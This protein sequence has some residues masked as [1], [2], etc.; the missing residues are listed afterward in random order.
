MSRMWSYYSASSSGMT[1]APD[2][3]G[4][5]AIGPHGTS[6]PHTDAAGM[7]IIL[8]LSDINITKPGVRPA[9]LVP[10]AQSHG[11][12]RQPT[13]LA[14]T[15]WSFPKERVEIIGARGGAANIRQDFAIIV[16]FLVARN[17]GHA[18]TRMVELHYGLAEGC[19]ADATNSRMAL[20]PYLV[21]SWSVGL[22]GTLRGN[23]PTIKL[24][25]EA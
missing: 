22:F 16:V 18:T 25:E 3:D 7:S 6:A 9:P 23:A 20:H 10:C 1:S 21:I 13:T 12:H 14:Q 17:L 8:I 2:A 4:V 19:V 11:S 24:K 15:V 5:C